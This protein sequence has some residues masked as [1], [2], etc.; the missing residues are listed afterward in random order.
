VFAGR[1]A[2]GYI[3]GPEDGGMRVFVSGA[4]GYRGEAIV[5]ALVGA[6]HEVTGLSRSAVKDAPNAFREWR[7][8]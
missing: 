7:A 1:R 8:A 6:G 4:T 3:A 5:A 2:A